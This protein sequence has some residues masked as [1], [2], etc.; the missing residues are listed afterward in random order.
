MVDEA[1]CCCGMGHDFRPDYR[2][3]GILKKSFPKV[4]MLAVT[5]TA[6]DVIR[7][8]VVKTLK[9]NRGYKRFE[10]SRVRSNLRYSIRDKTANVLDDMADF[11]KQQH[12]NDS[13]I[14]YVWSQKDADSIASELQSR[15]ISAEAYHAGL[16]PTQKSRT[17]QQWFDGAT[18][19]VV[20][21][22][23]FGLGINKGDVR[24]VIHFMLS[25][26]LEGYYQESGRAGRDGKAA[27]CVLY[28]N[29]KDIIKLGMNVFG[30]DTAEKAKKT[31]WPMVKYC[32]ERGNSDYCKALI[33]RGLGE[34]NPM[35]DN[36]RKAFIESDAFEN[37]YPKI[38]ITEAARALLKYLGEMG[39][40]KDAPTMSL[41]VTSWRAVKSPHPILAASTTRK[42]AVIKNNIEYIV[43][44]LINMGWI[45][46]IPGKRTRMS[47]SVGLYLVRASSESGAPPG[48]MAAIREIESGKPGMDGSVKKL[49]KNLPKVLGNQTK[50]GTKGVEGKKASLALETVGIGGK[51][52]VGEISV[53]GGKKRSFEGKKKVPG[54]VGSANNIS[55][56]FSSTAEKCGQVRGALRGARGAEENSRRTCC[57]ERAGENALQRKLLET[58]RSE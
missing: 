16:T 21:T 52:N 19:V 45:E 29:P 47:K 53:A 58:T 9:M 30:S 46:I 34:S 56:Y 50:Q 23:A 13:G 37:D 14:V 28:F 10:S 3:L 38:D 4:P 55:S 26:S 31:Y 6:T 44:A 25:K 15:R 40:G 11:V 12:K 41:L 35:F 32:L 27:D 51:E 57:G 43:F 39:R 36:V 18:K 5:A 2:K 49:R 33:L 1:H 24:F 8:D 20:A 22:I 7:E 17:Q 42:T 48:V 54:V